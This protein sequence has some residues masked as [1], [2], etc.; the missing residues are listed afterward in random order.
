MK[1]IITIVV[2]TLAVVGIGIVLFLQDNKTQQQA[3]QPVITNDFSKIPDNAQL[4]GNLKSAGLDVL[5][6]EGTVLHIHQH[7]DLVINGQNT[8]IPAD[9]G[10]GSNFI[11]PIHTHDTTG[12][13]H[14]ESP[15]VKDFKLSQFFIEWGIDFDNSHIGINFTDSSHKLV[16]GL[17]G[18]PVPDPQNIILKPHD[19][20][21]IWYGASDQTPALIKSFNFPKGL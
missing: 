14:V 4:L 11:S 5:S 8:Q 3:G 9:I 20:I 16:V 19:E 15:V 1:K 21:E 12:I 18:S 10:I 17:N 6:S 7:L 13:L 2:I